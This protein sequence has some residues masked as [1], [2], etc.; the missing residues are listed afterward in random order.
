MKELKSGDRVAPITATHVVGVPPI[1]GIVFRMDYVTRTDQPIKDAET[2]PN[3][4]MKPEQA[5]ALAK[6]LLDAADNMDK[7][8]AA[9]QKQ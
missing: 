4:I 9:Q 6:N 5:R 8:A 7:A 3:F 1:G 2:T